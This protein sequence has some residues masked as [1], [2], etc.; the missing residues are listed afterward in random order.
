MKFLTRSHYLIKSSLII[1]L[2]L[3]SLPACKGIG[4]SLGNAGDDIG[5]AAAKAKKV[6]SPAKIPV[7]PN[8][9]TQKAYKVVSVQQSADELIASIDTANGIYQIYVDCQTGAITRGQVSPTE[10]VNII[11]DVCTFVSNSA[12]SN[13]ST[14]QTSVTSKSSVLEAKERAWQEYYQGCGGNYQQ[15]E[16]N[17]REMFEKSWRETGDRPR[18]CG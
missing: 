2:I 5:Q 16:A 18:G 11:R 10:Q 7:P 15:F 17:F 8:P 12:E 4:H 1:G 14:N 3:C 6:A 13:S 9:G